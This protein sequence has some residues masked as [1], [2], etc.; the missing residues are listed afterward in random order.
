[1]ERNLAET[2]NNTAIVYQWPE[3]PPKELALGLASALQYQDCR[4][5]DVWEEV[6]NWLSAHRVAARTHTERVPCPLQTSRATT[7]STDMLHKRAA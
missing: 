6:R 1:M 7:R 5:D 2:E 3:W 4:V